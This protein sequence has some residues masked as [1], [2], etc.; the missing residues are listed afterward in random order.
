MRDGAAGTIRWTANL[1]VDGGGSIFDFGSRGW[2][3]TANTALVADIGQASVDVNI[4][5]YYVAA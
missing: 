1:A 2:K 3:L 4:T 5:E